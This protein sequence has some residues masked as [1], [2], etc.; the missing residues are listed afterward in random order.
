MAAFIR[1]ELA[2]GGWDQKLLRRTCG[3]CKRRSVYITYRLQRGD[4]ERVSVK[5]VVGLS[6]EDDYLPMVWETF[7]H[8]SPRTTWI[9]FKYQKGRS[10]WGLTK[11]LVLQRPHLSRLLRSYEKATG[12][13]LYPAA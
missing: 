5:H 4:P 1:D 10:P 13:R 2:P 8:G 3:Y 12:R 6:L 7:R 11:R 9:D